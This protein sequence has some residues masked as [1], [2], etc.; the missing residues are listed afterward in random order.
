MSFPAFAWSVR[1]FS[2][3]S[4]LGLVGLILMADPEQIAFAPAVFFSMWFLVGSS[5]AAWGLLVLYRH[6]VGE[7]GVMRF[8]RRLL[9]Q[10]LLIGVLSTMIAAL[11]YIRAFEWWTVGLAIALV[12]LIEFSLRRRS[13]IS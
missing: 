2:L 12:L 6:F 4:F 1:F 5:A 3:A 13:S 8:R 10:A 7:E 11:K 9:E